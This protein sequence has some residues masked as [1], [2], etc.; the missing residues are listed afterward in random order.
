MNK[1]H[2]QLL[3][4]TYCIR[5]FYLLMLNSLLKTS[6]RFASKYDTSVYTNDTC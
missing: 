4:D 5:C 3:V 2:N 1:G 6:F